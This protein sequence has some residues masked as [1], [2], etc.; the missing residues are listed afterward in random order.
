MLFL[1]KYSVCGIKG[2]DSVVTLSFYKKTID[3]LM[4]TSKYNVKGIYGMNGSGKSAIITS[5]NILKNILLNSKYLSNPLVQQELAELINKK[6]NKISIEVEFITKI[7]QKIT[8]FTYRVAIGKEN[9]RNY[10]IEEEQ[11]YKR[12]A[13]HNSKDSIVFSVIKGVLESCAAGVDAAFAEDIEKKTLNLLSTASFLGVITEKT[14]PEDIIKTSKGNREF[15]IALI[16][17]YFFGKRLHVYMDGSDDHTG[18]FISDVLETAVPSET[19][20]HALLGNFLEKD[21]DELAALSVTRNIVPREYYG[22]F[23]QKIHQLKKFIRIFKK[24]LLDIEIDKKENGDSYI[25]NLIMVY[26]GY[27]VN[28]EFESTGIKKLVKLFVFL[29]EMVKGGIVFIDELDS[30]LHDVYLCSLLEYLMNYGKG[31]L[32]F[33]THNVGPM[34]VLKKNKHSI[35]F[36]SEDNRI[37]AWKANGNYSPSNLYRDGMVEG[38]PFNVDSIDFIGVLDTDEEEEA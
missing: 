2:I 15:M 37:V 5:V 3:K 24:D 11:L 25:C 8:L 9:A 28:S 1:S 27:R 21:E 29:Q 22:N 13:S 35:D 31:Q 36:L 23:E 10:V 30:N 33:T 17:L 4:N 26:D 38:S 7:D 12:S 16:Y 19:D 14:L 20:I 34:D 18:Y 6:L 32:C